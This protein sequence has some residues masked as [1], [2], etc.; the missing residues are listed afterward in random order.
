M[1]KILSVIC[2]CV[3]S[4]ILLCSCSAEPSSFYES[5][6]FAMD[7]FLT[8][9][10]YGEN[11]EE[12]SVSNSK[13]ASDLEKLLSVTRAESDVSV[14]NAK[15]SGN[16]SGEAKRVFDLAGMYTE[17]TDKNFCYSLGNLIDL[18][19]IGTEHERVP[20]KEEIKKAVVDPD[21]ICV[22]DKIILNG[23]KINLGGIAKG[24]ALDRFYENCVGNGVKSALIDFGGSICAVGSKPNG[25]KWSVGIYNPS[26]GNL[27]AV[28][29]GNDF[30]VSTSGGYER[31]FEKD[32]KRY[33]HILDIR[34]GY[35]AENGL[36]QVSV[37]SGSGVETDVY[38]TA[39]FVMGK[40]DGYEFA[41]MHDIA[42]VFLDENGE[43]YITEE[44]EKYQIEIK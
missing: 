18:W 37:I 23:T 33:H 2:I 34:T 28:I 1:K 13:I 12:V 8:Q 16:L 19:G 22:A 38:S 26:L 21:L 35:P 14:L 42:A 32:G 31:F 29:S 9:T 3:I 39:L 7:T 4:V 43:I 10:V 44:A 25:E 17:L 41:E 30:F 15:G 24:Y 5:Q 40:E 36:M 11:A 27:A 6:T 20:R